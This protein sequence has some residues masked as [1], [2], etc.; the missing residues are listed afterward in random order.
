MSLVIKSLKLFHLEV[1][2]LSYVIS[3]S[4]VFDF[5]KFRDGEITF[6]TLKKRALKIQ[7]LNVMTK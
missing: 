2:N 6:D 3:K 5:L 1:A 7:D 4:D